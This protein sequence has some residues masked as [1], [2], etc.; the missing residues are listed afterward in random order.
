MAMDHEQMHPKEGS[1][2]EGVRPWPKRRNGTAKPEDRG[3]LW[4]LPEL[5]ETLVS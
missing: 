1:R 2:Q 4:L 5:H 3:R